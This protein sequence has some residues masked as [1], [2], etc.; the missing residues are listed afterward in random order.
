MFTDTSSYGTSID[1]KP[2]KKGEPTRVKHKSTI[3]MGDITF[4][5]EHIPL[6]FMFLNKSAIAS[7]ETMAW[8]ERIAVP[9][10]I[11]GRMEY[12]DTSRATHIIADRINPKQITKRLLLALLRGT[13]VV[14]TKWVS[15]LAENIA[16]GLP[17]TDDI[18]FAPEVVCAPGDGTDTKTLRENL[19]V[20][21]ARRSIFGNVNVVFFEQER[22][23]G[24]QEIVSCG[25]GMPV[26]WE[27]SD[28]FPT[29]TPGCPVIALAPLN[30]E[31]EAARMRLFMKRSFEIVDD[32]TLVSSIMF[33]RP[34]ME[35]VDEIVQRRH[36]EKKKVQD[37][38][39]KLPHLYEG[40]GTSAP[41]PLPQKPAPVQDPSDVD[42]AVAL[43]DN[44]Q[45][46]NVQYARLVHKRKD[47][48][49]LT[50]DNSNNAEPQPLSR[51]NFKKSTADV[52]SSRDQQN[53]AHLSSLFA[54]TSPSPEKK[55]I[56]LVK[57]VVT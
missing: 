25:G 9:C 51:K 50:N 20:N 19:R 4:L 29:V 16:G 57:Y 40:A 14:S 28:F 5:A 12:K 24:F 37:I 7:A 39:T 3:T 54:N 35:L 11:G 36:P 8:V 6:V 53:S 43:Q 33:V 2:C 31:S 21:S 55:R 56:K 26:L 17:S 18:E 49:N 22:Y 23:D 38:P 15:A 1:S 13:P 48:S 46:F 52:N 41:P 10:I 44:T 32:E 30:E 45:K 42:A 34:I 27:H 47:E